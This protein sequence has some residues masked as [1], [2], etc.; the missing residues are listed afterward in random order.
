MVSNL[1]EI[2]EIADGEFVLRLSSEEDKDDPL[3][4]IKFSPETLNFLAG[5]TGE[6]AKTMIEAGIDEAE[7]RSHERFKRAKAKRTSQR[8][9]H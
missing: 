1:L 9:L 5:D 7:R 2:V 6:V 4:S 3:I 8:I